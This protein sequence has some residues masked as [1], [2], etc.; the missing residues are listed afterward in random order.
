MMQDFRALGLLLIQEMK[1]WNFHLLDAD[2]M[3]IDFSRDEGRLILEETA[4]IKAGWLWPDAWTVW[5]GADILPEECL[6]LEIWRC[7]QDQLV[8]LSQTRAEIALWE[9]GMH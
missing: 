4:P 3:P 8:S 2:G 1:G 7:R 5:Y 6:G 9:R